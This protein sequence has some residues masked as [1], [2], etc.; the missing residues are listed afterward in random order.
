MV[1]G[2]DLK[3]MKDAQA[4]LREYTGEQ[5]VFYTPTGEQ[6]PPGTVLDPQTNRPYDALIE[7]IASG[8]ASAAVNANLAFRPL[9][10]MN[11]QVAELPIGNLELGQIVAIMDI[12]DA[13]AVADATEFDAKGDHYKITQSKDDGI[14]S[15]YRTLVWGE[16]MED[17]WT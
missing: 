2:P 13:K 8:W 12:A 9:S 11:D 16:R 5:I 17:S 15:N 4:R 7:P 14:G 10:G 6:W 3:G 1:D